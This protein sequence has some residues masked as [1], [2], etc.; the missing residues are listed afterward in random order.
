MNDVTIWI[1]IEVIL[2]FLV[3]SIIVAAQ[4]GLANDLPDIEKFADAEDI[5]TGDILGVGYRH[6]FAWFVT[7]WSFSVWTH[8]GIAWRDPVTNELFV[9]EAAYYDSPKYRGVFRIP[10]DQW[11]R[12]NKN[13]YMCHLKLRYTGD[14][15]THKISENKIN[16]VDAN[17]MSDIFHEFEQIKILDSLNYKWYRFLRNE[18]YVEETLD[19]HFVCYEISILMLQR[20]GIYA[21]KK[22][23]SSHFARDLIWR[24]IEMEPG[25]VYEDP[26]LIKFQRVF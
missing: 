7:A 19:R 14:G 20:M 16:G 24:H 18:P 6:C 11:I 17:K 9:L 25:Y 21:K 10:F 5:N 15:D 22:R 26:V 23:C 12:I 1:M 2:I 8:T 3:L 13:S 4:V